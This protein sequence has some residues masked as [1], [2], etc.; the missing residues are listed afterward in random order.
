MPIMRI[1]LVWEDVKEFLD[2]QNNLVEEI[3]PI[4]KLSLTL[5]RYGV[6]LLTGTF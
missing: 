2:A 1:Q 6:W 3:Y 4:I 5:T